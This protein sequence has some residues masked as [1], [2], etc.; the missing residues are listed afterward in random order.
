MRVNITSQ[1]RIKP[2]YEGMATFLAFAILPLSGFATDIYLPSLP[3][4]ASAMHVSSL[5]VQVTITLYLV[6][7][8][9]SQLF[10]GSVLDSYGRYR[11]GMIGLLIFAL[12]SLTI[13]NTHNIYVIDLMRII[14]GITVG[15]IVSGKRAYFVDMFTGERLKNYVSLFSIIWSAGPIVAPFLGGYL[16]SSFGWEANFYMLT[17]STVV[18]AILEFFF[19][20]ESLPQTQPFQFKRIAGVYGDMLKTSP[21]ILGILTLGLS[22]AM[23]MVYNMTGPF[24]I[25]H[26]LQLS[27]VVAGYGSL[28]LGMGWMVGGFIGKATIRYPFFAK[29]GV[30]SGLLL[31]VVILMLAST[32][33]MED[34]LYSLLIFAFLIHVGA[35][36]TFNNYMTFCMTRFPKNAGIA[37][38]LIG[39]L[40]FVIISV[41]SYGMVNIMP[42]HDVRTLGYSYLIFGLLAT[43]VLLLASGK[44]QVRRRNAALSGC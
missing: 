22:Y 40:T 11:I 14:H 12:A 42:A 37:S 16:Q 30:N 44:L 13:A 38:G 10:I 23:V 4:M 29:L 19:S 9:I 43:F 5:Q 2:G 26:H 33:V 41:T 25:E 6:S 32:G 18:L 21:F 28:I 39:G 34:N 35:G 1:K 7:Y 3:A 27:A 17:I 15:A 20:G 31:M 24:I 36:F 8:G